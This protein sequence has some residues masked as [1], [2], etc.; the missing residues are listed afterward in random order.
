MAVYH[1]EC[2]IAADGKQ[3]PPVRV[4]KYVS[5]CA[6]PAC[7]RN[8]Q[9]GEMISCTRDNENGQRKVAGAHVAGS[10]VKDYRNVEV[11]IDEELLFPE[12]APKTERAPAMFD[13]VPRGELEEAIHLAHEWETKARELQAKLTTLTN[14]LTYIIQEAGK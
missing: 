12:V 5:V 9:K 7:T 10:S 2:R 11:S 14:S 1:L 3:N 6:H 8:I 13:T 4:A